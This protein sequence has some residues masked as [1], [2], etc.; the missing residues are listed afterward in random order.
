QKFTVFGAHSG[1]HRL[2]YVEVVVVCSDLP[3][4]PVDHRVVRIQAARMRQRGHEIDML[5]GFCFTCPGAADKKFQ[6]TLDVGRAVVEA[7]LATPMLD[8]LDKGYAIAPERGAEFGDVGR[9][10]RWTERHVRA[11]SCK[12]V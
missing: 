8:G 7:M 2:Q 6:V 5:I 12:G 1:K 4:S 3:V 11:A 9:V 10:D